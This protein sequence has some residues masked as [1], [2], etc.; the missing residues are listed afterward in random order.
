MPPQ[1]PPSSVHGRPDDSE[2]GSHASLMSG[3]ES[4]ASSPASIG[5]PLPASSTGESSP[6]S[7]F[8]SVDIAFGGASNASSR[9]SIGYPPPASMTVESAAS[10]AFASINGELE[11][12]VVSPGQAPYG[13]EHDSQAHTSRMVLVWLVLHAAASTDTLMPK[14]QPVTIRMP[15]DGR[16]SI[17][18]SPPIPRPAANTA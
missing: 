5:Y 3:D 16:Q 9:V 6:L 13:C 7:E 4:R 15:C 8:A 12:G 11:S 10:P 14:A 18:P 2:N 1:C 17:G